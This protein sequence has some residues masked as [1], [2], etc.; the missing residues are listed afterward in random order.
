M[1]TVLCDHCGSD[2]KGYRVRVSQVRTEDELMPSVIK[3]RND[4]MR[5][6]CEDC[7]K[8]AMR[9]YSQMMMDAQA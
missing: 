4:L 5:D 7:W 1:T 9:A 8:R 6:Y 2:C 3:H